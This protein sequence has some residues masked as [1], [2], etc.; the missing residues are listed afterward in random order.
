M[1][2]VKSAWNVDGQH[3]QVVRFILTLPHFIL[4]KE[5]WLASLGQKTTPILK[6]E[7]KKRLKELEEEKRVISRK[8][9]DEV[10]HL[11]WVIELT[12]EHLSLPYKKSKWG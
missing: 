8:Y 7:S 4:M 3:A 9:F 6:R 5:G 1:V 10:E 11:N 12:H 2:D